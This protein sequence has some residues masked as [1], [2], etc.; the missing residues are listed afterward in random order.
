MCQVMG[1][2]EAFQKVLESLRQQ[3][4]LKVVGT[5]Q[6]RILGDIARLEQMTKE[7]SPDF[8]DAMVKLHSELSAL[9]S[10]AEKTGM[11]KFWEKFQEFRVQCLPVGLSECDSPCEP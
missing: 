7:P 3:E 9:I 5:N 11:K 4:A 6:A 10:A 2:L 1:I 8:V